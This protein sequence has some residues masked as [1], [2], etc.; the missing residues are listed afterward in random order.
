MPQTIS[1]TCAKCG[2][3]FV[4]HSQTHDIIKACSG[5]CMH[6]IEIISLWLYRGHPRDLKNALYEY[7]TAIFTIKINLYKLRSYLHEATKYKF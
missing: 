6:F 7:E 2:S 1:T 3:G 4:D 5:Q